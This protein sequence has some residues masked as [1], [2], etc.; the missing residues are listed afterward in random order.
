M[1]A[2]VTASRSAVKTYGSEL[3]TRSFRKTAVSDAAY[4]RRS[5]SARA[6]TFVRPRTGLIMTGKKH[7]TAAT[8]AFDSCWSSPNQLLKIGANARIG[9]ELA[10]TAN[11]ISE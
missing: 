1:V 6:S 7:N 11:G 8:I 3:G 5:S 10:A 2:S 9:I 4:D